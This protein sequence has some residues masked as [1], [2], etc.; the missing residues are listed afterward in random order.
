[1]VLSLLAYFF[2]MIG[3]LT[4]LAS[5]WIGLIDESAFQRVHLQPYPR[6]AIAEVATAPVRP[7]KGDVNARS[8]VASASVDRAKHTAIATVNARSL[9]A[10]HERERD[11]FA[12]GY[13]AEPGAAVSPTFSSPAVA[14]IYPV[15]A[16]QRAVD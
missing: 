5:V 6:P 7:P 15:T 1:M 2:S 10:R 13:A 11:N 9:P 14:P 3:A 12:L 16:G 8:D 4:V